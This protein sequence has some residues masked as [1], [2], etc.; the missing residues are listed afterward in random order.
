[1]RLYPRSMAGRTTLLLIVGLF[2]IL[3]VGGVIFSLGVLDRHGPRPD[4]R[5]IERVATI[6]SIVDELPP[7]VRP[8]TVRK[9]KRPGLRVR[10]ARERPPQ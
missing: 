3:L 6:V 5:L 1:M 2:L 9:M 8:G 7:K 4:V 10:W